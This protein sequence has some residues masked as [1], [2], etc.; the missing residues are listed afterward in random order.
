[1]WELLLKCLGNFLKKVIE[2]VSKIGG[3]CFKKCD[4]SCDTSGP[5]FFYENYLEISGNCTSKLNAV[6]S[7][8]ASN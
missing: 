3:N 8:N 4:G 2:T 1:M 7:I 5:L 6:D